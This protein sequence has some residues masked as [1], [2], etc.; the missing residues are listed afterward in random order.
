V[1]AEALKN[2]ADRE[3][4]HFVVNS[5]RAVATQQVR[6]EVAGEWSAESRRQAY[7]TAPAQ[8]RVTT[9]QSLQQAV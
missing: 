1:V 2:I 7:G 3:G 4:A 8:M 5:A 6:D 9:A